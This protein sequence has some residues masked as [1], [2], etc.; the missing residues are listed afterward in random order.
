MI[1][2][3][4]CQY[5]DSL[6]GLAPIGS[7]IGALLTGVGAS[8]LAL[9]AL[10][11]Y[12]RERENKTKLS[13][14][15][16]NYNYFINNLNQIYL[17]VLLKNEGIVEFRTFKRFHKAKKGNPSESEYTWKDSIETVKYSIELQIKKVK[18]CQ[19]AFDW[20]DP[21]QYDTVIDH[22][23]LLKDVEIPDDPKDP[24]FYI[25]PRESYHLGCWVQLDKGLYEA[26]V[27]VVGEQKNLPDDFWTCRFPF[28]V[29]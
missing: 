10:L 26:K 29:K 13:I 28:E 17:D 4:C 15:L 20:F 27:I 3:Y 24:P 18:Q 2:N 1:I 5:F 19:V 8:G 7:A 21:N 11:K 6:S 14:V 23:N 12:K 9:W 22:I 16:S 25:E